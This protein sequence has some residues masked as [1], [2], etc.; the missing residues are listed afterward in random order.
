MQTRAVD[1]R[2][3]YTEH[4]RYG[5]DTTLSVLPF[6]VDGEDTLNTPHVETK[7]WCFFHRLLWV[8]SGSWNGIF[9]VQL[10]SILPRWPVGL[11]HV[12]GPHGT[13]L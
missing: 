6:T 5:D 4:G 1:M 13:N 11:A 7:T 12:G 3:H 8:L 2:V 9:E 10:S